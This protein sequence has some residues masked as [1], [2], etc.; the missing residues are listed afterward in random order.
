MPEALHNEIIA[1]IAASGD[2][3][4][5][6]LLL[7]LLRVE[8][9]FFERIDALSEQLTVPVKLHADDHA[10][11]EAARSSEGNVK[12]AAW[13]IVVGV[14]EKGAWLAVGAVAMKFTGGV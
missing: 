11:I 3:N 8:D 12:A 14:T 1:A 10:W 4:Y 2:E 13:K 9:A 7:L 6:R 5:K